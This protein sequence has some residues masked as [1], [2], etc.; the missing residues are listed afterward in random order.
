MDPE[1]LAALIGGGFAL[2]ATI[3]PFIIMRF[4]KKKQNRKPDNFPLATGLSAVVGIVQK[5]NEVLLVQ[6]RE[7][8]L[9]LSWQFPAGIVKSG[10]D[11]RDRVENEVFQ[12]TG[13][14]CKAIDYLGARIPETQV[15]CNYVHC[16]YIEGE[17]KNLDPNE[18][19]SS[20]MG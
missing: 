16:I 5:G 13:I 14:K 10:K 3:I 8:V 11:I 15:L 9:N 1:I 7:R 17:A 19:Y 12:E 4:Q 6:R 18:K 20:D 2:F